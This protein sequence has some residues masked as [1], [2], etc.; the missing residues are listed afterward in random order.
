MV[1]FLF[2]GAVHA[3]KRLF[4]IVSARLDECISKGS[5]R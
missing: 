3:L 2:F 5:E 4:D 1:R